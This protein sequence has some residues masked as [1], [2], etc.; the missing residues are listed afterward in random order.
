MST[1]ATIA[2]TCIN[3][4]VAS[5]PL[6]KCCLCLLPV[7]AALIMDV[8]NAQTSKSECCECSHFVHSYSMNAWH[9][10]KEQSPACFEIGQQCWMLV[11][12]GR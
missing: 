4:H 11:L 12:K 3:D 1:A 10:S 7:P 5:V 8:K 9:L 2:S 6:L